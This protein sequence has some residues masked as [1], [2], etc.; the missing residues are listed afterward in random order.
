MSLLYILFFTFMSVFLLFFSWRGNNLTKKRLQEIKVKQIQHTVQNKK[1]RVN[2][3]KA[4]FKFLYV[5]VKK[6]LFIPA[7]IFAAQNITKKLDYELT[8][9]DIPLK[10]EEFLAII[11]VANILLSVLAYTVTASIIKTFISAIVTLTI[12]VLL[13]IRTGKKRLQKFD[14]QI[15]DALAIISH[16]IR[17]GFSFLQAMDMVKREMPNP[18]SIEFKRTLREI[19]LGM[20]TEEALKNLTTRIESKDLDMVITAILVQRKVGGNLAEVLDNIAGTIR[21]RIRIKGELRVLTA[22]GRISGIIIGLLPIALFLILLVINPEYIMLLFSDFRGV[23]M[24]CLAFI[25]EVTGVLLI[26]K[27]IQVDY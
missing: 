18:I 3:D 16:S 15:V 8:K 4:T 24:L 6:F 17:S 27:I 23:V 13:V 11:L 2:E 19:N 26:N 25:L 9:A 12:P 10:G 7:K 20:P 14:G 1:D 22:Q 5:F 21:D